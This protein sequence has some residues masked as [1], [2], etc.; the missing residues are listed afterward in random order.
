MVGAG[1]GRF[2][3][4]PLARDLD[5]PYRDLGDLLAA[6]PAAAAWAA[7]CAPAVAV[8]LLL[9]GKPRRGTMTTQRRGRGLGLGLA[10]YLRRALGLLGDERGVLVVL[11]RPMSRSA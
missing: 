5:R 10:A 7:T 6:E 8:A 11:V 9:A 1:C 4:E 2:L 3:L